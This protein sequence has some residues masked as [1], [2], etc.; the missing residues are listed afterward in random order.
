MSTPSKQGFRVTS[1]FDSAY[2]GTPPW[3]IGRPQEEFVRIARSVRGK[4]DV[5][6]LGCGTGEQSMLFASRGHR[7]LG[8]DLAPR[9]IAKARAK[10]A[11]R[12]SPSEFVVADALAVHTLG[13][14]FDIALD[15]GL[16]HVFSDP[17]RERYVRALGEVLRPGGVYYMLCF[18]DREPDW[19]G[20]RRV[21]RDEILDCFSKGWKVESIRPSRFDSFD[22]GA[23]AEAWFCK[24]SKV[25]KGRA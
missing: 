23:G 1:F 4:L 25:S 15:S 10:A 3:D 16:F 21:R 6:D 22:E 24:I 8:V 20:P 12:G 9:A 5:I 17:E 2:L 11:K 7:V 13:R 14:T 18:S 19:G